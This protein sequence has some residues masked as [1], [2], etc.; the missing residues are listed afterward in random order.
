MP[1]TEEQF[2]EDTSAAA[3]LVRHAATS[4][5]M[6]GQS[7]DRHVSDVDRLQRVCDYFHQKYDGA[8]AGERYLRFGAVH[9]AIAKH[10]DLIERNGLADS[11]AVGQIDRFLLLLLLTTPVLVNTDAGEAWLRQ[12]DVE[13][14]VQRARLVRG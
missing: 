1:Y 9:A 11:D 8:Q 3:T 6:N 12:S 4:S 13:K 5:S 2:T 7:D 14:A 10:F